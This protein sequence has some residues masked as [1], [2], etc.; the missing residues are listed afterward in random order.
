MNHNPALPKATILVID[1]HG[2]VRFGLQTLIDTFPTCRVVDSRAS[3]QEGVAAI[4]RYK[5]DLVVCDMSLGD[6]KGLE[7]VR[8][9]VKAQNPRP[10]LMLSM[11]DEI[12]Y[13]EQT[14]AMGVKGYLMKEHAQAY[15]QQAIDTILRG[16][17][18]VSTQV[19]T[20]LLNRMMRRTGNASNTRLPGDVCGLS[21]RELEVLEKIGAGKT[22][23]EI[24]FELGLS[25]RTV[26]IHRSNIKKKLGF[27]R[28]AEIMAFA[29]SRM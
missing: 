19:S 22:T 14:L 21:K 28:S 17:I 26:D 3:L 9:V 5:P 7:T 8:A 10:V 18:W 6:S 25:P 15:V 1:D 13:A 20:Y 29:V 12:I 2:I 4:E 16:E 23:K 11:H 24:A 27:K